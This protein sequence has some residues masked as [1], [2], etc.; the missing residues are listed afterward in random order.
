M[1]PM[2]GMSVQRQFVTVRDPAEEATFTV[3]RVNT[4]ETTQ[5]V[6]TAGR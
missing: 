5:E 1:F 3:F 6:A 4:E 2:V